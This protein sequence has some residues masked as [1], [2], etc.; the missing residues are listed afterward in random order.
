MGLSPGSRLG[1]YETVAPVGAGGMGEVYRAT[2]TR[3]H[4]TVAIKIISADLSG[5][6]ELRQRF[7]REA[8]AISSLSH[9][10]ICPLFDVGQEGGL[11]YLV[12]EYLEGETLAASLTKRPLPIDQVLRYAIE[13][14]SALD[15][16][17]RHGIVHRDLKPGNVILTKTGAKLLDFG[18]AKLQAY[19][20][21]LAGP[22]VSALPTE[23]PP[24]TGRHTILGTFH[25]MAPEL[26]EG[27]EA[28]ARS[29]LFAFGATVYEM[30]TGRK[31][32]DGATQASVIAAILEREPEP[33]S[34]QQ[35]LTPPALE[36]LVGRCLM[37]DPDE[38]W[39]TAR[40]L[41][42]EL[43]WVS[44]DSSA[45]ALTTP[46]GSAVMK[47][48]HRR[49]AG[50]LV[51][52]GAVVAMLALAGAGY[53]ATMRRTPSAAT[54]PASGGPE[55][56]ADAKSPVDDRV[57]VGPFENRTGDRSLDAYSSVIA[58]RLVHGLTEAG[59]GTIVASVA[60][61]AGARAAVTG[62][63]YAHDSML[64]ID[65]RITDA[66]TGRIKYT[67]EPITGPRTA[68]EALL[69]KLQQNV[70]GAAA[71]ASLR[72][73]GIEQ[74]SRAPTY[75]AYREFAAGMDL[76]G[77]DYSTAIKHFERSAE[78]DSQFLWSRMHMVTAYE[79]QGQ[80]DRA[81][82]TFTPLVDRRNRLTVYER[83]IIDWWQARIRG[84]RAEAL[85]RVV[86]AQKM[87]PDNGMAGWLVAAASVS[88]NRP[89]AA[90]DAYRTVPSEMLRPIR[91]SATWMFWPELTALHM[92]GDFSGELRQARD[93]VQFVPQSIDYRQAE[94]RALVGAGR[95]AEALRVLDDALALP[96]SGGQL[97]LAV[98]QELRA[99]GQRQA[100]IDLANR[101]A[102]W[103]RSRSTE[104]AAT[105]SDR[106]GLARAFYVAE[107]W[108][109]A[110]QMF[111]GEIRQFPNTVD[112]AGYLG[113]LA[114]RRGDRAEAERRSASLRSVDRPYMFG[115]HTFWRGKIATLL[116]DEEIAVDLLREAFAQ[117]K[118]FTIDVHR[119]MDLEPLQN[120]A[121]FR[122]LMRPKG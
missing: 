51:T 12:L 120:N 13:I 79:N 119:D 50:S 61:I 15:A 16:A 102:A 38:R 60:A 22:A 28:D 37:K 108:N 76:F 64:E 92:I 87:D 20:A 84:Q 95:V 53:I 5:H 86:E 11:E 88:L 71:F 21:P 31:A 52:A 24:L 41:L 113:V 69:G 109:N 34:R 73:I 40:D 58:D 100:S 101:A 116:H 63:Y 105:A 81:L 56:A 33:M 83:M 89:Q 7:E 3:L 19:V 8:R 77:G 47:R 2:D 43:Q 106:F 6:S 27:K 97:M 14:A 4:R 94:A 36:R 112:Y 54:M 85:A 42:A 90:L 111:E 59:V 46:V 75:G 78:L 65:A 118:P 70:S 35:P 32:F 96:G 9:P 72:Y 30:A 68:S 62:A 17:H 121:G 115:E 45:S 82:E 39:Q 29:D 122:G 55:S 1:P 66:R 48:G 99:H 114:A 18:L 57:V 98:A 23:K 110:R 80:W 25:Y 49:R 26:L 117:G 74:L 93:H 67:F 104:I 107:R 91:A 44:H 10:H 103:Y